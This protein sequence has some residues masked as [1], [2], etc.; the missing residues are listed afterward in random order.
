MWIFTKHG[1]ISVSQ[2]KKEEEQFMI[3]S[4]VRTPLD[5]LWPESKISILP[6]ADYRFRISIPKTE[7][8][9]VLSDLISSIDYSN[10]KNACEEDAAYHRVLT[11]IWEK[12]WMYQDGV[13]FNRQ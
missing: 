1:F 6:E 3:K 2:H 5:I 11:K 7:A 4:R 10:F 13:E 12:L 9:E 8:M